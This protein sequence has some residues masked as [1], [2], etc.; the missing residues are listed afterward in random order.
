MKNPVQI[1]SPIKK[2]ICN[3]FFASPLACIL[4]KFEPKRKKK[5]NILTISFLIEHVV[6]CRENILSSFVCSIE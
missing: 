1:H 3:I 4:T 5:S 6:L 2:Q